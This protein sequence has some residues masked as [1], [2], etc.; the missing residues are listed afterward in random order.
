MLFAGVLFLI[1]FFGQNVPF[2][3]LDIQNKFAKT[4]SSVT[5]II[6]LAFIV[7]FIAAI[8]TIFTKRSKI[9]N[10]LPVLKIARTVF[11]SNCYMFIFSFIFTFIS[12][13][14][15][16][17]NISLLGICLVRKD[18]LISPIITSILVII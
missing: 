13:G 15:L 6:G 4:Q 11:W 10:I 2:L 8:I 5:L 9:K 17:I 3:S 12:I 1:R 18:N 16:I 14:A 7:G